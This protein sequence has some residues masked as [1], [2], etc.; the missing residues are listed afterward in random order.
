MKG[1]DSMTSLAQTSSATIAQPRRNRFAGWSAIA[2]GLA[3]IIAGEKPYFPPSLSLV[4]LVSTLAFYLGMIPI[5]RWM[6]RGLAARDGGEQARVI[7]AAEIIGVT[8]V[9]VASAT[10]LL[11]LPHWLPAVPAQIIDTSSLGVIGLWLIVSTVLAFRV[12]LF[13]RALAVLGV[14]AGASWLLAAFIMWAELITGVHGSLVPTLEAL[15]ILAG[16]VGSALYLIWAVWLGIWLLL[17]KR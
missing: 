4:L 2:S 13:N 7:R 14:L 1:H 15:R 12:R 5:A 11:A 16:Y 8:G 6:A 10:A 3:L 17:R 9:V